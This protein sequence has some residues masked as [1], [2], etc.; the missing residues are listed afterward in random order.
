MPDHP[1]LERS[2]ERNLNELEQCV[3]KRRVL[4]Q[5]LLQRPSLVGLS[6]FDIVVSALSGDM[7][8][9][10]YRVFDKSNESAL[11]WYIKRIAEGRFN[12]AAKKSGIDVSAIKKVADKLPRLRNKIGFHMD[13]HHIMNPNQVWEEAAITGDEFI[14]LTEDTHEILRLMLHD[15]SGKDMQMPAYS[16]EDVELVMCAYEKSH[17][18]KIS[19]KGIDPKMIG[20]KF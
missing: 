18:K 2:L 11:Y 12:A 4:N 15:L 7:H 3:M 9:D 14:N 5:I 17:P 20:L 8:R 1:K 13:K 19:V 10:A 16:A 6:F